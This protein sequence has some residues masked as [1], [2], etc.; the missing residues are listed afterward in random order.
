MVSSIAHDAPGKMVSRFSVAEILK[1][2]Q[3][4]RIR[5]ALGV[6]LPV[7]QRHVLGD[8]RTYRLDNFEVETRAVLEAAAVL[9]CAVV[10]D[11]AHE[12]MQEIAVRAVDLNHI[13]A[14]LDGADGRVDEGLFD[15]LDALLGELLGRGVARRVCDRARRDDV[16]GPSVELL[17]RGR[18]EREPRRDGARLAPRVR[19]LD[20]DLLVLAVCE[21]DDFGEGGDVLVGPEAEVL[22]RDA[23]FWDYG[24]RLEE[25][26]ARSARDDAAHWRYQV[27]VLLVLDLVGTHDAP[28]A[29][30][31]VRRS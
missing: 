28:S 26:E 2:R 23:P 11:R 24:G 25:G 22:W 8:G 14:S 18:V 4:V 30:L 10:R 12:L 27:S 17:G 5:A 21:G 13:D 3:C 1:R 19:E 6:D 31:W 29:M 7:E 16:V 20:A 15:A 9:V